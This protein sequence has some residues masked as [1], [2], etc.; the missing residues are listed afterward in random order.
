[1][2]AADGTT[3]QWVSLTT[4]VEQRP[5]T[6]PRATPSPSTPMARAAIKADCNNVV[7]SYTT[8]GS[9]LRII[10]GPTTLAACPEDSLGD[11]FV[12]NLSNAAIYFFQDGDLFM[13]MAF[14][15]GTLRFAAQSAASGGET[16]EVK[17]PVSS[18]TGIEFQVVSFGPVGAEQP[19]LEG[20]TITAVFGETEV[21][22]LRAATP[23]LA[24]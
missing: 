3:W 16:P 10:P 6:T 19:V 9:A 5:L 8:D 14:D 20:T 2:A 22:G 1:M 17:L 23:T 11:Q 7:A 4:P 15:S 13:D 12:A 21:T 24:R 18:A